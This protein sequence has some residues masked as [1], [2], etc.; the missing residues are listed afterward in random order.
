MELTQLKYFIEVAE[1]QHITKSA[2]HLHI[3]QPALTQAIHRLENE[4]EIPLFEHKG[5]GI[6]L[7]N[8]GQYFYNKV[9]P[10]V[11]ELNILPEDL[12]KMAN[13]ESSTIHLN[14]L[15]ASKLV[16]EAIIEYQRIC[17]TL[18]IEFTQNERSDLYDICITTK[19]FYQQNEPDD[20]THVIT[21]KIC[22]AVPDNSKYKNK[23]SIT[24]KEVKDENFISLQGSRQLRT[25]CDKYCQLCGIKPNII[26]ESDS[27]EAVKNM[28]AANIGIGFW[29]S[30]SWGTLNST[31]VKLLEITDPVC[32]RDI[33]IS[34]R[35]N[36]LKADSAE[37]FYHYLCGYFDN[38]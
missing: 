30:F 7:N 11:Q 24:L 3:A 4:L 12:R 22:L 25:I 33:L 9:K 32:S 38:H 26:F 21:E 10:L 18:K 13:L 19:L 14:V 6:I 36:K 2:E 15:A 29:P 1:T 35:H 16:S 17:D 20:D 27:P 28:I 23:T 31:K 37:N 5:R 34:Y 8:Y